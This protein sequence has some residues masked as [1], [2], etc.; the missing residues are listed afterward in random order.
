VSDES[1]I[2][3]E[4]RVTGDGNDRLRVFEAPA[5]RVEVGELMARFGEALP[6][7]ETLVWETGYL[8]ETEMPR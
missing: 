3:I 7:F 2:R 1:T 6:E 5:G 8:T 4:I